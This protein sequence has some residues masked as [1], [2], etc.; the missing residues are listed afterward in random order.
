MA[1][2]SAGAESDALTE[3]VGAFLHRLGEKTTNHLNLRAITFGFECAELLF[4]GRAFFHRE[5]SPGYPTQLGL[6]GGPPRACY[7][8]HPP[9]PQPRACVRRI[10]RL[11]PGSV[12]PKMK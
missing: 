6:A 12:A 11:A 2:E 7:E 9:S 4:S 1:L 3:E 8:R 5:P 10:Q